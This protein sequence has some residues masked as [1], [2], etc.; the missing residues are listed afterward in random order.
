[1]VKIDNINDTL[2]NFDEINDE[3]RRISLQKLDAEYD[4]SQRLAREA[5]NAVIRRIVKEEKLDDFISLKDRFDFDNDF[6]KFLIN[7]RNNCHPSTVEAIND[8][9]REKYNYK[10]N[11]ELL[12]IM[13]IIDYYLTGECSWDKLDYFLNGLSIFESLAE[14]KS[15]KTFEISTIKGL[16]QIKAAFT[17]LN[18]HELAPSMRRQFCHNMTE[19]GLQRFPNLLGAYYHIPLTFSGYLDHSVLIDSEKDM[20]YDLSHNIS[21]PLSYFSKFFPK[22]S[23]TISSKDYI[24]LNSK[25]EKNGSYISMPRIEGIRRI[26]TKNKRINQL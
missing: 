10:S 5:N 13:Q 9:L 17:S 25:L 14:Y 6:L 26:R 2:I 1:M 23:F 16:T 7:V 11:I 8:L 15:L 18:L 24:A 4:E 20:L 12:R 3:L 19:F 22:P 21:I